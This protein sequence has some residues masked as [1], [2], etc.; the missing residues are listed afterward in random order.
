MKYGIRFINQEQAYMLVPNGGTMTRAEATAE[1][2]RLNAQPAVKPEQQESPH[3]FSSS[4]LGI[5][6]LGNYDE[7]AIIPSVKA[8]ER[9]QYLFDTDVV[10]RKCG[11]S[12]NFDG[13]MFT[14][15]GGDVCDDC[16]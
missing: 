11:A 7:P 15:G 2:N 4:G 16:F 14:N 6:G 3:D 13:A 8:I 10:C 12:K 5:G 9:E 1:R